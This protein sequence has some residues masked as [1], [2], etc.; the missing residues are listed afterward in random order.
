MTDTDTITHITDTRANEIFEIY[1][2]LW[3]NRNQCA[4]ELPIDKQ[5]VYRAYSVRD[6][7]PAETDEQVIAIAKSRDV[8]LF[9]VDLSKFRAWRAAQ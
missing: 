8:G 9:R 7:L 2:G 6:L 4:A 1:W 5:K 3:K